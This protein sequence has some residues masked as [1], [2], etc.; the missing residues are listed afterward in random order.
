MVQV[1]SC[2][3]SANRLRSCD[4]PRF[5]GV[6]ERQAPGA[7]L[8][9]A[10]AALMI[11]IVG[12][13][14][15]PR[16]ILANTTEREVP[17]GHAFVSLGPGAPAIQ[18]VVERP[19]QNATRQTVLLATRG[20]TPGENSLRVDVIGVT[21]SDINH[22]ATLPD[23]PLKEAD[24]ISEAQDALPTVPLRTSLTYLQ[25]RYGPFG[26]AVGRST[27]GDECIYAWQRLATPDRD[28]SLI[29]SRDTLSLRLRLCEPNTSE[30]K[31]VATM[32][33]LN[34]SVALS[35][36]AWIAEPKQLSPEVGSPGVVLGPP[37][38][39]AAAD[40]DAKQ[41]AHRERLHVAKLSKRKINGPSVVPSTQISP[42]PDAVVVPPP[43]LVSAASPTAPAPI[44][45]AP[46][47]L[48]TPPGAKP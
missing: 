21:N 11:A 35:D 5:H 44:V 39:L 8:C 20:N 30:A 43:P 13:C 19:Y 1:V 27:Q 12:G 17:V 3:P 25:N 4:P 14:A 22:E 47:G 31:L 28:L 6:P 10:T 26:Y 7:V 45:S 18:S 24:L 40:S 38:V 2:T 42:P 29:N 46:E 41:P 23:A 37:E 32:M 33:K 15:A 34:V 16:T 36:G 9:A 48:K